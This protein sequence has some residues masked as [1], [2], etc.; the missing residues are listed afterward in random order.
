MR[1]LSDISESVRSFHKK[2]DEQKELVRIMESMDIS[3][4]ALSNSASE[5]LLLELEKSADK[6]R[7]NIDPRLHTWLDDWPKTVEKYKAQ[8]LT[9]KIRERE[10]KQNLREKSLSGLDIPLISLPP[11]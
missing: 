7:E 3:R 10:I 5:P 11:F 6:L 8:E 4:Q 9:F 1:Y 2:A